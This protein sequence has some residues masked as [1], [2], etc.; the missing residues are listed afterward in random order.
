MRKGRNR[1]EKKT[2]RRGE[3]ET[4]KLRKEINREEKKKKKKRRM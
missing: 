1:Q 3:A 2:K 4:L